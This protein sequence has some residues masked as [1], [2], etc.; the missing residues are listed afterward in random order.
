MGKN[1]DTYLHQKAKKIIY[2]GKLVDK[3]PQGTAEHNIS[4]K[5]LVNSAVI[6]SGKDTVYIFTDKTYKSKKYSL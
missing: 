6:G 5:L 3:T 2:K 4:I 1:T